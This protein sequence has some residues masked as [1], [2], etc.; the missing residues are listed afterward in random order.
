MS[1]AGEMTLRALLEH[2]SELTR[3]TRD[4]MRQVRALAA[5]E[6][7]CAGRAER[8]REDQAA[9]LKRV[10]EKFGEVDDHEC[11]LKRLEDRRTRDSGANAVKRKLNRWVLGALA[12]AAGAALTVLV[13][14]VR[15]WL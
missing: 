7:D 9:S 8:L 10:W 13:D 1:D 14:L 15:G 11:R 6:Q 12:A 5:R 3:E 2:N 4:E